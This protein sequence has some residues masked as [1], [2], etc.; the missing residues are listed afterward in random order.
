MRKIC[1]VIV[2][3]YIGLLHAFSQVTDSAV[4][5]KRKLTVD[6]VNIL[7]SYYSQDGNN[8]AVTGGIGTEALKDYSLNAEIKMHRYDE[9]N[10]KRTWNLNLGI[11]YYTSASSDKIDPNTISSA[12]SE[13]LHVYP[14]AEYIVENESKKRKLHFELSSSFESDYFSAGVGTGIT[15]TS[16]DNNGEFSLKARCYADQ[17]RII[18]PY[19]FRTP[20]TG[21]LYNYDNQYDYPWKPRTSTSVLFSYSRVMNQRLQ[22]LFSIEPAAQFGFLSMP[23]HRVY[24]TDSS[25][26]T[27]HLPSSRLKLP[28][29]IRANYFI[30]NTIILRSFYR[31]YYDGWGLS[32]H[33]V[34]IETA[35]KLNPF[36]SI[37]PFYR[38]YTQNGIDYFAPYQQHLT[39]DK[40]YSSNYDLS[41]FR[42]HFFGTGIRITPLKQFIGCTQMEL[43]FGHYERSNALH[44]DVVSLLLKLK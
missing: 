4:Y 40:F 16:K 42:S 18:L 12:S 41:P 36:F 20:E 6:E 39:T 19:E 28:I 8:S 35:F 29:G 13:D 10:R 25:E 27:E 7:S 30:G 15:K 44:S 33:T 5:K 3:L 21:G 43:R 24:F 31:F 14:S 32:A 17:V 37:S 23:F 22:M 11:D 38:F 26:L 2:G 9:H 1:L 34:D